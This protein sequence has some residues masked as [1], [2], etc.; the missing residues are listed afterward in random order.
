MQK[1]ELRIHMLTAIAALTIG[2]GALAQAPVP[3]TGLPAARIDPPPETSKVPVVAKR[4][5]SRNETARAAFQTMDPEKRGYLTL[6]D[7]VQLPGNT[8]FDAADRNRDGRLSY[9]EFVPL[10]DKY[11]SATR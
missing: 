7:L 11:R 10:W 5:P 9:E 2:G 8:D 1:F 3:V 4:T 6:S